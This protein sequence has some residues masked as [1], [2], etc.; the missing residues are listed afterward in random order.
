M[1]LP[2]VPLPEAL[3]D[4]DADAEDEDEEV[5]ALAEEDCV[6]LLS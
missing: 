2:P 6:A 4:D 3:P 5:D 1:T